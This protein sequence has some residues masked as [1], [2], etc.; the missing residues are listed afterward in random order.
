MTN[1]LA[2]ILVT[3]DGEHPLRLIKISD[4][5]TISLSPFERETAATSYRERMY[6][7][8]EGILTDYDGTTVAQGTRIIYENTIR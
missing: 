6:L 3:P 4:S 5:G 8:S 2:R 1:Y 7:D